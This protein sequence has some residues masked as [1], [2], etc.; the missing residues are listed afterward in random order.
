MADSVKVYTRY[1][2]LSIY[3]RELSPEAQIRYTGKLFY[4]DNNSALSD[5]YN[6][7]NGIVKDPTQWPEVNYPDIHCYLI[8]TAG[9]FTHDSLKAYNAYRCL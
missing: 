5:L 2:F 4:N 3:T 6:L 9:K 7:F 1:Y 8:E